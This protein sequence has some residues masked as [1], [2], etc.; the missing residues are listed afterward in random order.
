MEKSANL[1]RDIFKDIRQYLEKND[2]IHFT[3]LLETFTLSLIQ[4]LSK[5]FWGST[6]TCVTV[7]TNFYVMNVLAFNGNY[8]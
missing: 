2:Q 6:K 8:Y 7:R 1:V 4:M 3:S 5:K